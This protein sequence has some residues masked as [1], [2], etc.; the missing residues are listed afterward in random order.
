MNKVN[1]DKKWV[2]ALRGGAVD[3]YRSRVIYC[4]CLWVD[5]LYFAYRG[6]EFERSRRVLI[7]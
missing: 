1:N 7:K 5:A 6:S 3:D 2:D 4:F